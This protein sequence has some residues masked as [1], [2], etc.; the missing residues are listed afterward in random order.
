[1]YGT[2]DRE[3]LPILYVTSEG[4]AGTIA[5]HLTALLG[6]FVGAPYWQDLLKFSGG[7]DLGEM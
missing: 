5:P 6:T 3:Q 4:Q 7:G 2:G 1:V